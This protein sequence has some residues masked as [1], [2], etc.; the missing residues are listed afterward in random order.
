MSEPDKKLDDSRAFFFRLDTIQRVILSRFSPV[1]PFFFFFALSWW[2]LRPL[3]LRVWSLGKAGGDGAGGW[4]TGWWVDKQET[5]VSNY[6]DGR[7]SHNS[8]V[9]FVLKGAWCAH[10]TTRPF[11]HWWSRKGGGGEWACHIHVGVWGGTAQR[12]MLGVGVST[13]KKK[14]RKSVIAQSHNICYSRLGAMQLS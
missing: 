2:S 9:P 8:C 7:E 4:M 12:A 1:Y 14:K 5:L 10:R 13:V 3:C 11:Q 6:Y